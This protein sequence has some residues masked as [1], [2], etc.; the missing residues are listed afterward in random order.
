V[1]TLRKSDAGMHLAKAGSL[2][3][4]KEWGGTG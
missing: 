1:D 2:G 3:R 4:P